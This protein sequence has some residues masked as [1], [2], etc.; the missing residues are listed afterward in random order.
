MEC[1]GYVDKMILVPCCSAI[2]LIK[3]SQ[4]NPPKAK[5]FFWLISNHSVFANLFNQ[6][7]YI[8]IAT[9]KK[10]LTEAQKKIHVQ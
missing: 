8:K 9:L 10:S 4:I 2:G 6:L 7:I 5:H 1:G 3:H